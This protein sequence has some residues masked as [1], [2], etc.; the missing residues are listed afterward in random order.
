MPKAPM[1]PPMD[2]NP[3]RVLEK[4]TGKVTK[5]SLAKGESPKQREKRRRIIEDTYG[6]VPIR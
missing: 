3:T 6:H 5:G 2:E 4:R 1:D